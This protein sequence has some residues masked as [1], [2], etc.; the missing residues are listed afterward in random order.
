MKLYDQN[1]EKRFCFEGHL[2]T[3]LPRPD[4]HEIG[5]FSVDKIVLFSSILKAV[6]A[7]ALSLSDVGKCIRRPLERVAFVLKRETR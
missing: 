4:N 7:P 5:H 3:P 6:F 1:T 2:S